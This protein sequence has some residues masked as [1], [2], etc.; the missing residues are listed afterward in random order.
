[1]LPALLAIFGFYIA[2]DAY[3]TIRAGLS[4]SELGFS[5]SRTKAPV[6]FW[7]TVTIELMFVVLAWALAAYIAMH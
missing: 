7:L 2:W 4:N 1:L 6:S 3:R 5:Y